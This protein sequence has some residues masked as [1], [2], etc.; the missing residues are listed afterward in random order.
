M[1]ETAVDLRAVRSPVTEARSAQ[2]TFIA[3]S[4][5]VLA[6]FLVMPLLA[7]FVQALGMG[8]GQALATFQ[9]PDA[10]AAIKERIFLLI[11]LTR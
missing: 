1:A 11:V 9:D 2:C 3:L 6:L 10:I 8:L 7:V 5:V 4:V